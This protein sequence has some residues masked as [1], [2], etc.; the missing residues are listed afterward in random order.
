MTA[1]ATITVD[2]RPVG[3]DSVTAIDGLSF[4]LRSSEILGLISPS[5]SGKTVTMRAMAGLIP[6]RRGEI[7]IYG[8]CSRAC[9]CTSANSSV[10]IGTFCFNRAPCSPCSAYWRISNSPCASIS[11]CRQN[12]AARLR[13]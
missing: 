9:R 6:P 8:A 4:K 13:A 10:A 5:G 12:C 1:P 7:T 2:D 3:F 11:I